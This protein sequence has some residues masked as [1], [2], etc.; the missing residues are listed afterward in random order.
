MPKRTH[1]QPDRDTREQMIIWKINSAICFNS[2]LICFLYFIYR[3]TLIYDLYECP[4]RSDPPVSS[5]AKPL[6]LLLRKPADC[7][8]SAFSR[9]AAFPLGFP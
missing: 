6:S 1:M 7:P 3:H 9:C 2:E 8:L 4:P 5:E